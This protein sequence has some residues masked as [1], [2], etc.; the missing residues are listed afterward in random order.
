MNNCFVG[1]KVIWQLN[2]I[3]RC[4][5]MFFFPFITVSSR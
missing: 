2:H 4:K 1:R 3:S 5:N